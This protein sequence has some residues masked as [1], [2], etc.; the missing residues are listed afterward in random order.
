[1]KNHAD[2]AGAINVL[3]RGCR[4]LAC[5]EMLQPGR[6]KMQQPTEATG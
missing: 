2:V 3:E 5:A 6:S 4:L 1:M